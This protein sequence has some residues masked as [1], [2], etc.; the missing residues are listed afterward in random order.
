MPLFFLSHETGTVARVTYH[1]LTAN[2]EILTEKK[3]KEGT[4]TKVKILY[5]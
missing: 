5:Y 1:T 4:Q 2:Y 3:Q